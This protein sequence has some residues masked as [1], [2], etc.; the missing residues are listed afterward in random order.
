MR[1]WKYHGLGNDYIILNPADI[2]QGLTN[3]QIKTICH[4]NYG[5]GSDGI[6]FGPSKISQVEFDLRIFNPDGSEAPDISGIKNWLV[7]HHFM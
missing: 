3:E 5:V 4:R 1:F 6:L 7:L 2:P